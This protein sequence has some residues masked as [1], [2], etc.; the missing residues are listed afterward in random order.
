MKDLLRFLLFGVFDSDK[1][2]DVPAHPA[3]LVILGATPLVTWLLLWA[4]GC[5]D[6]SASVGS[7]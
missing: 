5:F 6:Y 4:F 7:P 1:W 3:W 2:W